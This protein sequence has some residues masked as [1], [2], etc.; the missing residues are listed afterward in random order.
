MLVRS[1]TR[2]TF[3]RRLRRSRR[4]LEIDPEFVAP[5]YGIAMATDNQGKHQEAM[6]MLD[7]IEKLHAELSP[8]MQRRMG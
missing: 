6:A 8:I 1:F 2:R 7:R 3:P 5:S 4:A